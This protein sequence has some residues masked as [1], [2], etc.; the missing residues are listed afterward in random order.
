MTFYYI[1]ISS[2][3]EVLCFTKNCLYNHGSAGAADSCQFNAQNTRVELSLRYTNQTK[4]KLFSN[5]SIVDAI[6]FPEVRSRSIGLSIADSFCVTD[7]RGQQLIRPPCSIKINNKRRQEAH[8]CDR[9]IGCCWGTR[10]IKY[11]PHYF[12][13]KQQDNRSS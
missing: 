9:I 5:L 4:K 11:S 1:K 7:D 10:A 12:V 2:C 13:C 8:V 6:K 3:H